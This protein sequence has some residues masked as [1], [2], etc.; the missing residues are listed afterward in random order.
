LVRVQ[1]SLGGDAFR[2]LTPEQEAEAQQRTQ[3]A[4]GKKRGKG[5]ALQSD[6]AL[7]QKRA[8]FLFAQGQAK[9]AIAQKESFQHSQII[10]SKGTVFVDGQGFSVRPQD[11]AEFIAQHE[12][13]G[14]TIERLAP[15][16][17]GKGEARKL[18]G[19]EAPSAKPSERE[20][21][22]A[23]LEKLKPAERAG[24]S[25][26]EERFIARTEAGGISTPGTIA[27]TFF[28]ASEK[29]GEVTGLSKAIEGSI[30]DIQVQR[31]DA[32]RFTSDILTLGFFGPA[33]ASTGEIVKAIAPTRVAFIDVEQKIGTGFVRTDAQFVTSTGEKGGAIGLSG[34]KQFKD[35]SKVETIVTGVKGRT[36]FEIPTGRITFQT[37]E[38]FIGLQ[39][40]V[41]R[42]VEE[43][44]IKT[45]GS[46]A[47]I[48]V[49]Q[50]QPIKVTEQISRGFI[51][52]LSKEG[53]VI[54]ADFVKAS[55]KSLKSE[56]F[57][58][59]R[60][61][62]ISKKFGDVFAG[63]RIGKLKDIDNIGTGFISSGK[64]VTKS[65]VDLS[66]QSLADVQAVVSKSVQA[67]IKTEVSQKVTTISTI[68][69]LPSITQ[70]AKVQS[71]QATLPQ[72]KTD[73]IIS[74]K[75][76]IKLSSMQ[77]QIQK[78]TIATKLKQQP[79]QIQQP[80]QKI[81]QKVVPRLI[82]KP[83]QTQITKL[84]PT[85][86]IPIITTT[87]PKKPLVFPKFKSISSFTPTRKRFGVA[88]R[89][90]GKFRTIGTGLSLQQAISFGFGRVSSTLAATFKI[91]P[92][93]K[94]SQSIRTPEGFKQKKGLTF[95]E[96]P[97]LRLGTGTEIKEIQTARKG[98]R[99]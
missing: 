46:K 34:V 85:I 90:R 80:V 96:A 13:Q 58:V 55:S 74:Q 53:E 19:F 8:S 62:V 59:V 56:G 71:I 84:I 98:G 79:I 36:K 26:R 10:A 44:V 12:A 83:I 5:L 92:T 63:G 52:R 48:G 87:P 37:Q 94:I 23:E 17:E 29:F 28:V 42:K 39:T 72:I 76:L 81:G 75:E 18:K 89:R 70:Q 65:L 61:E 82:P 20:R 86:T 78:Q 32:V 64:Q 67:P 31:S 97:K 21:V 11:Q 35:F 99:I 15:V 45:F 2:E 14:R 93:G 47:K 6:D 40:S 60:T 41:S 95:I 27:K 66:K 24:V 30:F 77:R 1:I 88:V 33:I 43:L 73:Q 16:W 57:D 69:K 4:F 25:E 3:T 22:I 7:V 9:F 49:T 54:G 51:G 91:I 50:I 38:G 68:T